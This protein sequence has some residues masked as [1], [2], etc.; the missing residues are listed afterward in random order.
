MPKNKDPTGWVF[1]LDCRLEREAFYETKRWNYYMLSC[2]NPHIGL[3]LC[4]T[5][6]MDAFPELKLKPGESVT[7]RVSLEF[8]TEPTMAGGRLRERR[9]VEAAR[10]TPPATLHDR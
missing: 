8:L 9:Q 1:S 6:F 3:S 2:E 4:P 5:V 10:R 7:V